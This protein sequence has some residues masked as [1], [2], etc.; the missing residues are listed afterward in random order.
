[1]QALNPATH[2]RMFKSTLSVIA[3][4]LLI[5]SGCSK[6]KNTDPD[7]VPEQKPE[8]EQVAAEVETIGLSFVTPIAV[9]L[10]GKIVNEGKQK[11]T[12]HGFILAFGTEAD[13]EKAP[14]I[15]LGA[16]PSSGTFTIK[17]DDFHLPS[18]NGVPTPVVLKAY[19]TDQKGI[20]FGKVLSIDKGGLASIVSQTGGK[21]GDLITFTG[22]YGDMKKEDLSVLIGRIDAKIITVTDKSIVVEV[23]KGIH[24]ANGG[25]VDIF[26]QWRG[27]LHEVTTS[28]FIWANIKDV[29]PNT[30][31]VG[32]I[33]RFTGDNLPQIQRGMTISFGEAVAVY[34]Y[35]QG[36]YFTHVPAGIS[37]DKVRLYYNRGSERI[38]S[39]FE[40]TVTPP[41][42]KSVTPNPVS[43][44]EPIAIMMENMLPYWEGQINP[45]VSIGEF[46][47]TVLTIN[48]RGELAVWPSKDLKSGQGYTITVTV[49]PHTVTAPEP[50]VFK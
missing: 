3:I 31:P 23:P 36:E 18:V 21:T 45:V 4:V 37:K 30:G 47:T 15:S 34:D 7:K 8:Q 38:E 29:Y 5:L 39:P 24:V 10:K 17:L 27:R 44:T 6:D 19:A 46:K 33:V 32:T 22:S 9:E 40:F 50:I 16:N 11:I 12:D 28:F 42:I 14:K 35:D 1:M 25:E 48:E 13:L 41:V 26:L 20:H 49:G 43:K 2:L